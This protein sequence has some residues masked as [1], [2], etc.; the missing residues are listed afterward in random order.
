MLDEA[1]GVHPLPHPLYLSLARGEA[2]A[3]EWAGATVRLADW[4]VRLKDGEPDAVAKETCSL[5]SFDAE[6]RVDWSRTPSPHP[7]RVGVERDSEGAAWPTTA[8][9]EQM[10]SL[11]FRGSA[12]E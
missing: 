8:Q 9:R 3:P 11:L 12:R 7:H 4:Y 2:T 6:G 5:M 1:D 10:T